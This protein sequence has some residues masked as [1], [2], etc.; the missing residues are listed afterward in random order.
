[1]QRREGFIVRIKIKDE[2][3][4]VVDEIEAIA[5]KGLLALAHEDGLKS[6]KTKI[7]QLPTEENQKTA[8]A[9]ARVRTSK[10]S[11][12][13]TGDACPTNVN[14]KIAPHIIRM[15]ET[16]ALA[17]AFRLAVNI[18]AVA[19]EELSED[20]AIVATPPQEPDRV[21]G[22]APRPARRPEGQATP[23][24]ESAPGETNGA[25]HGQPERFR[26][27]DDH[28]TEAATG[29]RR[30]MS[31]EQRKLLFR[32]AFDLGESR[33]T[34]RDRVLKALG[35]ERLEWATRANA[36]QGIDT[37]KRELAGRGNGQVRNG[38]QNG[39]P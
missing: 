25:A 39:A 34:V 14:R 27:R 17:R 37:L 15:A 12:T 22:P 8:V 38:A 1:M 3:G 18:G 20:I 19:I 23:P 28:P 32:L 2:R 30:A 36:S 21:T 5:F 9:R 24:R 7:L 10:G 33:E 35:V 4:N 11:F 26:G 29:D 16:R 13:A 31:D 6:V